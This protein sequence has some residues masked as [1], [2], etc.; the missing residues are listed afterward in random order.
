VTVTGATLSVRDLRCRYSHPATTALAGVSLTAGPGEIVVVMGESG[1]GKSTL[2][3]CV[4][5]L[6]PTLTAAECSGQ[7]FLDA[8][9]ILGQPV[10][11]LAVAAC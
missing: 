1:A 4:N 5:G 10:G 11:R 3:R 2:L 8:V 9:P 7:I 6:V